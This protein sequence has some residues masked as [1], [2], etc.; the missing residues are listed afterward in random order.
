MT[1]ADPA[2]SADVVVVGAGAAGLAAA[3]TLARAGLSVELL[4]A[5]DRVGGR[6]LSLPDVNGYPIE[7]GAEFVHGRPAATLALAREAGSAIVE[8]AAS[9]WELRDGKL[10]PAADVL[11]GVQRLIRQ[12]DGVGEELS[13]GVF[14]AR[15]AREPTLGHAAEWARMM[16]EG[17][18]A[19]DPARASLK[20]IVEEWTSGEAAPR[21][22]ARPAG[23]YGR[24]IRHLA[25]TAVSS[26]VRLRLGTAVEAVTWTQDD[27][28]V[29]ATAHGTPFPVRARRAVI[30]LPL[31]VL[32][33]PAGEPGTVRF[34]PGLESKRKALDRLLMGA[35]LR[36]V[37]RFSQP[38]WER[39][40]GGRYRDVG[41]FHAPD[42]EVPTFW[43][44]LPDRVPILTA[45]TGG[46]SAAKLSDAGDPE[47][48]RAALRGLGALFGRDV[49]LQSLLVQAHT[50][51]WQHDPFARGAYSYLAVGGLGAR[52]A[53]SEP[54][55]NTLFLAGE[56]TSENESGTVGG[57]LAAGEAAGRAV[58]TSLEK[59][60]D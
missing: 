26:G 47:I 59:R 43:T 50:H 29:A 15:F 14:L 46:P 40:A 5:Q 60:P 20:A 48:V 30:T 53:L 10:E 11:H 42:C 24:L 44:A 49:D 3:R 27:V 2:V 6:I 19:A 23:G 56:A 36:I 28:R 34:T 38:F 13:V 21:R 12:A 4:E 39:I 55:A 51:N 58:L 22:Q 57:A 1:D 18:D 31:G 45:W 41:F 32:Q 35:V 54:L 8:G 9:H 52:T 33:A 25:D 7:L 37:L 17:F 16:V